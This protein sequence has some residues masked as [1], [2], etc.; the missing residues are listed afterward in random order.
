MTPGPVR[1][2]V[3][4]LMIVLLLGA[5]G[6]KNG[7]KSASAGSAVPSDLKI[8]FGQQGTF[9]GRGMGYSIDAVGDVVKWEGKY[10][11]EIREAQAEIDPKQVRR[12]WHRAEEIDFLSMKDQAMATAHQFITVSAGGESRRVT[13]VA[14]DEDAPTPAQAFYDECMAT[15]RAALGEPR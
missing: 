2:G 10:P 1:Y 4:L 5:G 11:G 14:R 8:V 3:S 6:C 15:A 7:E 9:A 12:L 13:W